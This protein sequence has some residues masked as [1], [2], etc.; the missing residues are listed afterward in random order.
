VSVERL[1][2]EV[3][4]L[5]VFRRASKM[6]RP[7]VNVKELDDNSLLFYNLHDDDNMDCARDDIRR[8]LQSSSS[9]SLMMDCIKST[10]PDDDNMYN[11]QT[12]SDNES[13]INAKIVHKRLILSKRR[14][15]LN[16]EDDMSSCYTDEDI[17]VTKAGRTGGGEEEELSDFWDQVSD[18]VIFQKQK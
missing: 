8:S 12:S 7:T 11:N 4:D 3:E 18:G 17:R 15:I 13:D 5:V 16:V 2:M 6:C 14:P 9:L 10:T 1:V